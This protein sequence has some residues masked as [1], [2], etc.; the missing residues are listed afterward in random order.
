[1]SADTKGQSERHKD[2]CVSRTDKACD[3]LLEHPSFISW[4]RTAGV[5][6]LVLL[7]EMGSGKSV[8]VSFIIDSLTRFSDHQLPR[9]HVCYFYCTESNSLSPSQVYLVLISSL[10]IKL[11]GLRKSF[12]EWY[13]EREK[14]ANIEPSMDSEHLQAFLAGLLETLERPIFIV[15]DGLDECERKTRNAICQFLIRVS[16]N[17]NRVKIFFS[18]RIDEEVL[19]T[20]SGITALR[21]TADAKRD[22][23]IVKHLVKYA[24]PMIDQDTKNLVV[25]RLSTLAQ[26]SAIWI[27]MIIELIEEKG[28]RNRYQMQRLLDSASSS[29]RLMALYDALFEKCAGQDLENRGLASNALKILAVSR[30]SLSILECAWAVTLAMEDD[31][32]EG[33]VVNLAQKIDHHRITRLIRPF[34]SR[35]DFTDLKKRQVRLVHQSVKYFVL[36]TPMLHQPQPRSPAGQYIHLA[37]QTPLQIDLEKF[38]LDICIA[39]LLLEEVGH[40]HVFSAEQTIL[41]AFPQETDLYS[42]TSSSVE[43]NMACTWDEW[44]EGMIHYDPAARGLGEFFVYAACYWTEHLSAIRTACL[45]EHH[46]LERLCEAKSTRLAN[47][48]EQYRRPNCA[49]QPRIHF[50]SS[51]YDPLSII[52]LY[53]PE[54]MMRRMV[55]SCDFSRSAYLER[56]AIAAA[57]QILQWGDPTRLRILFL[58]AIFRDQLCSLEVYQLAMVDWAHTRYRQEY[59][60]LVFDLLIELTPESLVRKHLANQVLCECTKYGCLPLVRRLL[61]QDH[62]QG[63]F[64]AAALRIDSPGLATCAAETV[65]PRHLSIGQAILSGH[66]D[67]LEYLLQQEGIEGH[68]H[69]RNGR[70]ENVLHLASESCSLDIF[71]L[72]VPYHER[73]IHQTD[74]DGLTPLLRIIRSSAGA[75]ER[76]RAAKSLLGKADGSSFTYSLWERQDALRAA[77]ELEDIDIHRLLLRA[78]STVSH[79][80]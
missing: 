43:I 42:S 30:R 31:I 44:E 72:L 35:L 19:E 45:P 40:V 67:V 41:D 58:N 51:L 18:S 64:R 25:G 69:Y 66:A 54:P 37:P 11:P 23:L 68:L 39:Y 38:V 48:I 17:S 1:M 20:L 22:H 71:D 65:S 34:V 3:W 29:D 60:N 80:T 70:G 53:G 12:Y 56:P 13:K 33:S 61:T 8:L 50:E 24:L 36:D 76:Y 9:P 28:I 32:E 75:E 27:K 14:V 2:L 77:E 46:K 52:S 26:G 10:L 78:C 4:Y 62:D 21:L 79:T 63:L 7:G 57:G 49:M 73:F 47:W 16:G 55:E 15:I 59:W 6:Q 5:H 74:E